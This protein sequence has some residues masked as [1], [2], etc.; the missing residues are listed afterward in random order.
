MKKFYLIYRKKRKFF[1]KKSKWN[2]YNQKFKTRLLVFHIIYKLFDIL[3][4]ITNIKKIALI[5]IQLQKKVDNF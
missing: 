4:M 5:N 1:R 3:I 2:Y